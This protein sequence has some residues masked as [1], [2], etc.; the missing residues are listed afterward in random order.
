MADRLRDRVAVVTGSGSGIGAVIARRFCEEGAAVAVVDIDSAA[1]RRV[2]DA[3]CAAGF[4]AGPFLVDVGDGDSVD[5]MATAVEAAFGRVDILVNNAMVCSGDDLATMGRAVW[6]QDIRVVLTGTYECS[7][8][9]LPG[10]VAAGGGAIVNIASVNGQTALGNDAYSA[11][12]AGVINLT[13]SIAVRYGR[14]GVRANAVV[15]GTIRTPAWERRLAL[16]PDIYQRVSKWY[17]LGRVGEPE[18]V[19]NATVFLA[20]DEA[21]WITGTALRVDGGLMAGNEV[22]TR[23]IMVETYPP[24][25]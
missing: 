24:E 6:D 12:K 3:L 5:W 20:S 23:E 7:R 25:G 13:Q 4:R 19:A 21:K 1:A 2:A 16:D 8:R 14:H 9:M 15:P 17:P 18:D 10:M 11:A 22:M